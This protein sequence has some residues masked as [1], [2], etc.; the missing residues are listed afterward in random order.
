M[1]S[2]RWDLH[3]STYLTEEDYKAYIYGSADVVGLMCLKIFVKGNEEEYQR[4]QKP[5]DVTWI[6]LSKGEFLRDLKDD[7]E[8][9]SRSYFPDVN[10]QNFS[11][12][13]KMK[14]VAEIEEDF[15]HGLKGYFNYLTQHVLGYTP[16]ISIM[17]NCFKN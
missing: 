16:L 2:M 3:K 4:A 5:C 8:D 15:A 10:L 13:D 14:I 9:L 11:E 7:F 1:R 6:C 17:Q 12:E